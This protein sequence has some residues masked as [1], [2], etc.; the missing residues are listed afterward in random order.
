MCAHVKQNLYLCF[1]ADTDCCESGWVAIMH[2]GRYWVPIWS[3]FQWSDVPEWIGSCDM[4]WDVYRDKQMSIMLKSL[5]L[6]TTCSYWNTSP[7][8][9]YSLCKVWREISNPFLINMHYWGNN[10]WKVYFSELMGINLICVLLSESCVA[11]MQVHLVFWFISAV[12]GASLPL[13]ENLMNC[14]RLA[15]S[16]ADIITVRQ[17]AGCCF[18]QDCEQGRWTVLSFPFN[19]ISNLFSTNF[20]WVPAQHLWPGPH[21]LAAWPYYSKNWVHATGVLVTTE[22]F[23]IFPIPQFIMNY[24]CARPW[25]MWLRVENV[26]TKKAARAWEHCLAS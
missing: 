25:R 16:V 3:L 11:T 17:S 8:C 13:C 2:N 10:F 6:A 14:T 18:H 20:S 22:M 9:T 5:R 1:L 19:L 12:S 15:T 7:T 21:M 24:C 26:P 4:T 23:N